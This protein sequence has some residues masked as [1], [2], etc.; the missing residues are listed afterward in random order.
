MFPY[1]HQVPHT[2]NI[3]LDDFEPR[4]LFLKKVHVYDSFILC[5]FVLESIL[6][7]LVR[8]SP[9][10]R[11]RGRPEFFGPHYFAK[12]MAIRETHNDI[13][14]LLGPFNVV[15]SV[16]LVSSFFIPFNYL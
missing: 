12:T 15:T 2:K 7:V 11:L 16:G 1:N 10:T 4:I 14:T 5:Y 8:K 13:L 6:E 9:W 3:V